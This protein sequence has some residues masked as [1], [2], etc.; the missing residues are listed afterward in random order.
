M[1]RTSLLHGGR[2]QHSDVKTDN[3][4]LAVDGRAVLCDLGVGR[5]HVT[6]ARFDGHGGTSC[7]SA[8]LCSTRLGS[9]AVV[10]LPLAGTEL[11][12]APELLADPDLSATFASGM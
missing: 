11:Y 1:V 3:V 9:P 7:K 6:Q 2:L 12:K 8:A 4:M 5:L 10:V